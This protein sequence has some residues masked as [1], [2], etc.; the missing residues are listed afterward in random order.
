MPLVP[1]IKMADA[2]IFSLGK[3]LAW[4]PLTCVKLPPRVNFV[5]RLEPLPR[6]VFSINTSSSNTLPLFS[7]FPLQRWHTLSSVWHS[8]Y[9]ST[10]VKKQ[11]HGWAAQ[12][13]IPSIYIDYETFSSLREIDCFEQQK[14]IDILNM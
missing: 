1:T 11:Q 12:A 10:G 9:S 3:P 14:E 5:L 13:F 7:Q 4:R 2:H 6:H 8:S